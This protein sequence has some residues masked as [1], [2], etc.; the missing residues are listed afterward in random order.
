MKRFSIIKYINMINKRIVCLAL[1]ALLLSA[2]S[3]CSSQSSGSAAE[4]QTAQT[5]AQSATAA[6]QTVA[7]YTEAP[8][9]TA[10]PIS[11]IIDTY[12]GYD[13]L[14][15]SISKELYY[16]IAEAAEKTSPEEVT[17]YE[18]VTEK[19]FD[20]AFSAY[21]NDHPEKF[22]IRTSYSFSSA[23]G[24]C[25]FQLWYTLEDD[26]LLQAQDEFNSVV[27]DI[28]S[29]APQDSSE[30]EREL[31]VNNYL[32]K[33]CEY[34]SEAAQSEY[35]LA[36]EDNAYGALVDRKAVCVGYSAA[37]QLLCNEL[38]IDCVRISATPEEG[39]EWNCVKLDGN[40]Y[41]VD[42]TWNDSDY[43]YMVN[44]YLNL[45]D[46]QMYIDHTPGA[47][48]SETDESDFVVESYVS[49]NLFVPECTENTYNYYRQSCVVITD[50]DYDD[51][52]IS[53]LVQAA[54]N[55]EEYF[56]LVIDDCLDFEGAANDIISGGYFAEWIQEANKQSGGSF[57]LAST[58]SVSPKAQISVLTAILGYE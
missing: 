55:G 21:L 33:N 36:N 37:F 31:Y 57:T 4:E 45:T 11:E 42:V 40:W 5:E 29:N 34:D 20:E 52:V 58:C 35:T 44:D 1:A 22:W 9:T 49:Y 23:H 6:R 30:Y 41:H 13:S 54:A 8:Q 27:T 50:L 2:A 51:E 28:T 12:Y 48:F 53:A 39:H 56:S 46:S 24:R 3:C 43:G 32:V 17:Y 14:S 15:N 7:V 25:L 10:P 16:K 18:D 38:D 47:Y 19:Q 26:E